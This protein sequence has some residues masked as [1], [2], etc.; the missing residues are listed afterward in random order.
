MKKLTKSVL[1][2]VLSA[3]F[4]VSYAQK[5]KV[6]T[7]GTKEIGEVVITGALG[8]K[9]KLDAQTSATT[10]VKS[11]ELTQA[12]SANA[13]Q[14]LTGKVTGLQI[15]QSNTGVNS[16]YNVQLRGTRTINGT[17]Q[18]L[19]VIDNVISTFSIYSQLPPE[20]IESVNVLKGAQGAALY[21]SDGV[22]G[23]II[24]TTKKG[25]GS[26]KVNV[27]LKSSAE[28]ES[29][30]FLPYR[31]K[32]Y[33]Q[34][35]DGDRVHVE[36]G[37]W[38]PAYNDPNYADQMIAIGIPFSDVDGNG[39]IDM[40]P[41]GDVPANDAA[42]S[43]YGKYSPLRDNVKDFFQTGTGYNHTV[44]VSAGNEGAYASL[45][46]DRLDREFIVMNDALKKTSVMFKGGFKMNNWSVDG[47]AT[48]INRSV[49]TTNSILY[50]NLLQSSSEIPITAFSSLVDRGYA[51]NKYYAN[52]YW[53]IKH[54]RYN[55]LSNILNGTLG[56]GYKVNN[57]VSITNNSTIQ[58]TS[59]DVLNYSDGYNGNTSTPTIDVTAISSFVN[60]NNSIA[61]YIYND[62]M[63]NFD[64][65]L[66]DNI[67]LKFNIGNNIQDNYSKFTS[68]G[69]TGIKLPG[70][71]Q[72]WNITTPTQ[73]YNL[74]NQRNQ[75]RKYAFYGNLD[76][77]YKDYLYLNATGRNEWSSKL[78][79]GNNSYFYPSFGVSF[80]PLN[81]LDKKNDFLNRLVLKYSWVKVGSDSPIGVYA[82]EDTAVLGNGYP[83]GTGPL[84]F[85]LNNNPTDPNI[86]P[87]FVTTNEASLGLGFLRDRITL[88]VNVYQQ[89]TKDLIT[90]QNTSSGSGLLGLISNVGNLRNRGIEVDLGLTPIKTQNFVWDMKF[91]YNTNETK[92]LSLASGAD[93]VSIFNNGI[94]GIYAKVGELF[95]LIKATAYLRDSQGRII[96][97][98]ATGDPYY[99]N[100]LVSMGRATPKYTLGFNTN[101]KFK[102]FNAYAVMDYRT[103][104][105]FYSGTMQYFT[106]SGNLEQS[107]SFD[108]T[109]GGYVIPNSVYQDS[110]GNY[111]ANTSIKSG[112]DSYPSVVA[113]YGGTYRNIG[114]NFI[115]DATAF[116]VRELGLG[117]SL[118]KEASNSI[119]LK[120]LSI[121]VF[122]R[123]P[124]Y[125]FAK[126]NKGYADPETS[127]AGGNLFGITGT[128]QYPS[129]KV[130]GINTTINF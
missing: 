100:N 93:E 115:L 113:Y 97:N 116:K 18:P 111:V 101:I 123:N 87:E 62:L 51:W 82:I 13:I 21:G 57:H 125:K 12:S 41:S 9:K 15:T 112:G 8:I 92:I 78:A 38:G 43:V 5:S 16:S 124:F 29:I 119:G 95:P 31:Q 129:T 121:G 83:Y 68:A 120:G 10:V 25:S 23:A 74:N 90:N 56:L 94:A 70:I 47:S 104:H 33:G 80:L 48:Y 105:K 27:Q 86:K 26:K 107:A 39:K 24:V 85:V 88:D 122:A 1:A 66:T 130:Y 117:Y 64:Y 58:I 19:V 99:T 20:I 98:Q 89:D 72:V 53:N 32:K 30:S 4:T 37:S 61:R 102:N 36:N 7:A 3:S 46:L 73:P 128:N 108:R 77:S 75:S 81:A 17:T 44:T 60:Q 110:S 42:S 96:I 34:G 127:I 54:E 22:N 67:N 109:Q 69:G 59:G 79:S 11:S 2:V 6:D 65:D 55:T 76:L 103:G 50:R 45:S 126:E 84:S 91:S 52:P 28:F 63:A 35:W 106:F 40:N 118:S 114:E 71:Y 14:A 49:S